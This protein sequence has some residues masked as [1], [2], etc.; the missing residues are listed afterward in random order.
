MPATVARLDFFKGGLIILG[1]EVCHEEIS[2]YF[3][4]PNLCRGDEEYMFKDST[5]KIVI[6]IDDED[7]GGLTVGPKDT[8]EISG[9]IDRDF[10]KM[11]LDVFKIRKVSPTEE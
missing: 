9:E 11:K 5:G 2:V 7:W 6:E 8:V 10:K 3:V 1:Q 4:R